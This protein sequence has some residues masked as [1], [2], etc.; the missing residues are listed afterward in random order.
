MDTEEFKEIEKKLN[1][2][3]SRVIGKR[4]DQSNLIEALAKIITKLRSIT[5]GKEKYQLLVKKLEELIPYIDSLDIIDDNCEPDLV[6]MELIFA[7]ENNIK[8]EIELINQIIQNQKIIDSSHFDN[9]NQLKPRYN[10]CKSMALKQNEKM[11]DLNQEFFQLLKIYNQVIKAV[12]EQIIAWD[13]F[14]SQLEEKKIQ[15]KSWTNS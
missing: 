11:N 9:I 13:K 4:Y 12:K 6:K 8:E 10:E 1:L 3:E 2:L 14:L 15:I 7:Q 5:T